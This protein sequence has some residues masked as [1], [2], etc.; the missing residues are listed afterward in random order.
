MPR[1]LPP[2][3]NPQPPSP[4]LILSLSLLIGLSTGMTARAQVQVQTAPAKESTTAPVPREG[5]WMKMHESF[6]ERNKKGDIDL[7]FLGDSITQ[8]WAGRDGDGQGP[9]Q[10]WNRSYA[11]RN[12]A[13]FGIGGDRT[14]HVLWRLEHGEVDGLKPKAVVLM[15]GTNNAGRDTPAEIADGVTAI[16]KALRTKLP[17]TK[18]LLLAVFPRS[19]KP[20]AI[21]ERL[22]SVNER[23]QKLD[24][25]KMIK[26]LDIGP[27][28]LDDDGTIS[29]DVMP[30]YLHLS[31]KGYRIWADSMEPTP[32]GIARRRLRRPDVIASRSGSAGGRGGRPGGRPPGPRPD[33]DHP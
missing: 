3:P 22:K 1:P 30:D 6:L 31:R 12:A 18:I 10:V 27:K 4:T 19:A 20:N 33:P 2:S 7:L 29:K 17:E 13:N 8:G 23:V 24:D 16:V 21:R 15:I 28:F 5:G 25:G 32:P 9:I 11:P 26:Y 14:Q